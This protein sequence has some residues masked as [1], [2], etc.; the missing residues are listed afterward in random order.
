[1]SN[2]RDVKGMAAIVTGAAR[3]I[4]RG[5]AETLLS[6]GVDVLLADKLELV[7]DTCKEVQKQYPD[8]RALSIV[9]DVSDENKVKEMVEESGSRVRQAQYYVEQCRDAHAH[10]QCVGNRGKPDRPYHCRQFQGH[11]LRL[12]IRCTA[13]DKA[14]KRNYRQY[15][16]VFSVRWAMRNRLPMVRPRVRSIP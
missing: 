9:L 4:G 6:E 14:E 12:Q 10:R 1:M 3:G 13:D 16:V 5:I 2:F 15:R 8:N 7:E 11:F